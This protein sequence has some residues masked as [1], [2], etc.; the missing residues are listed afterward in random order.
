MRCGG[1]TRGYF[2]VVSMGEVFLIGS[3]WVLW[4]LFLVLGLDCISSMEG[5]REYV[6][7]P[8]RTWHYG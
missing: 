7:S 5:S 8:R 3:Y 6:G 1:D 2:W 4:G